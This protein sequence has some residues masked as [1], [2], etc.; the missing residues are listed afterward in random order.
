MSSSSRP[1]LFHMLEKLLGKRLLV[2]VERDFG[3][4]GELV[5]ISHHPPGIWISEAEAVVLRSTVVNPVPQ[6]VT[7][8]KKHE[9]FLH[10]N[11]VLRI[12]I[13]AESGKASERK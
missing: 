4:E 7:K 1:T 8:E 3:Y 6:I 11:S 2:V 9:L 5:A 13:A 12:E 10:L